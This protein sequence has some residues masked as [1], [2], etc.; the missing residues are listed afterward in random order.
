M[1]NG[2]TCPK[3]GGINPDNK[4]YCIGCNTPRNPINSQSSI[5]SAKSS[6]INRRTLV[7]PKICASCAK[8]QIDGYWR[9]SSQFNRGFYFFFS[10][11]KV[12][13][14][15]VPV[16]ASC[17]KKLGKRRG[18][19]AWVAIIGVILF[20]VLE[21]L[22]TMLKSL[23]GILLGASVVFLILAFIGLLMRAVYW[24]SST[25]GSFNGRIFTFRNSEFQKQF[26]ELNPEYTKSTNM[27]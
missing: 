4:E 6:D 5:K 11:Y 12:A 19:W 27:Q 1:A 9:I 20:L 10:T 8:P 14:F 2:W 23:S 24:G 3:C 25:I 13:K 22:S 16:C 15:N 18:I 7:F 21:I 17:K 26:D